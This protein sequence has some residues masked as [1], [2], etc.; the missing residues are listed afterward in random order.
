MRIALVPIEGGPSVEL[1][2]DLTLVG[3]SEETD[4]KLDH[5]SVS[6]L[7][8]VLVRTPEG[9]MVR[10]LGSTN[11]TRINGQRVRRGALLNEDLL[12]LAHFTFRIE[13]GEPKVRSSKQDL[14][15]SATLLGNYNAGNEASGLDHIP[16]IPSSHGVPLGG[17]AISN[18]D[19]PNRGS[20]G[21][22]RRPC[23]R[24]PSSPP[25]KFLQYSQ[26]RPTPK[27]TSGPEWKPRIQWKRWP[28]SVFVRYE[29]VAGPL[30]HLIS[31]PVP[32]PTRHFSRSHLR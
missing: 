22:P 12:N 13:I 25:R 5:K 4:L 23:F 14:D 17:V 24:L 2:R 18:Y 3:R 9:L 8:C 31:F 6:K 1:G 30:R 15:S 20:Q 10:D 26:N 21:A 7:H 19:R 29:C 32:N 28:I 27:E 16:S 11:G